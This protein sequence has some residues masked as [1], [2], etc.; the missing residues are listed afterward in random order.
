MEPLRVQM[1]PD[2][3]HVVAARA[4]RAGETLC[5]I[6]GEV[7]ATPSRYSLQVGVD[8]HIVAPE[9]AAWRYT[10][11]SCHPNA[12]LR[13]EAVGRQAGLWAALATTGP[14]E[15]GVAVA[16]ATSVATAV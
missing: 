6:E 3:C 14:D 9:T 8:R 16:A 7:C 5:R 13:G 15:A 11:H 10:N 4:I 1:S 12:A 2:G